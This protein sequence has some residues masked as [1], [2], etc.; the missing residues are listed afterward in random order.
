MF[1]YKIQMPFIY[2]LLFVMICVGQLVMSVHDVMMSVHDV[3]MSVHD[4]M[5]SVH[6]VAFLPSQASFST[7][8]L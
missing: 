7:T 6:D 5:M 1:E 4:V 2:I 8:L 3:M